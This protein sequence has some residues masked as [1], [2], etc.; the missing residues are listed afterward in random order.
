M[1]RHGHS[2]DLGLGKNCGRSLYRMRTSRKKARTGAPREMGLGDVWTT[3]KRETVIHDWSKILSSPTEPEIAETREKLE[4]RQL[5]APIRSI[6][7]SFSRPGVLERFVIQWLAGGYR[8]RRRFED[9]QYG[10]IKFALGHTRLGIREEEGVLLQK[11]LANHIRRLGRH[12]EMRGHTKLLHDV[13]VDQKSYDRMIRNLHLWKVPTGQSS[14][15]RPSRLYQLMCA[16]PLTKLFR[17]LTRRP[18]HALVGIL[19]LG[20]DVFVESRDQRLCKPWNP[21]VGASTRCL[22][23]PRSVC[24]S[25]RCQRAGNRIRWLV[26]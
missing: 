17:A 23:H 16:A 2:R 24:P 1:R 21:M 7:R 18:H 26:S 4:G 15:R 20:A 25:G 12:P 11:A 22:R 14:T 13:L 6:A 10:R 5:I 9:L 3:L 19:M 8:A